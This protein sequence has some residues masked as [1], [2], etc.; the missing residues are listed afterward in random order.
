MRQSA[1]EEKTTTE[2]ENLRDLG[3]WG[4]EP[5]LRTDV[6]MRGEE[7]AEERPAW[8]AVGGSTLGAH[9]GLG[10]VCVP[11]SRSGETL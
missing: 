7:A 4:P 11:K 6:S 8:K 2:K 3:G 9:L 1:G 5:F 10:I